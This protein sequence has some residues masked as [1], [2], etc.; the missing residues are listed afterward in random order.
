MRFMMINYA[1]ASSEAGTPP[2]TEL[3]TRM[4]AFMEEITKAGVL[5]A[6]EGLHPTSKGVRVKSTG[7][8]FTTTDGPFPLT[9]GVMAGF[10]IIKVNSQEEAI[11]WSRRFFD[12]L[13]GGEGEIRQIYEPEDFGGEFTPE[14]RAQED[15]LREEIAGRS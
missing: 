5:L 6:G 10:A 14:L 8:A 3:M 12:V 4:G 11:E 15:R 2:D 7:G 13:G 1:D 9:N